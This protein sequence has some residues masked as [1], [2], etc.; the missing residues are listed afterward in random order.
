[1][2]L[3]MGNGISPMG[4]PNTIPAPLNAQLSAVTGSR[5]RGITELSGSQIFNLGSNGRANKRSR[6]EPHAGAPIPNMNGPLDGQRTNLLTTPYIHTPLHAPQRA[7]NQNAPYTRIVKRGSLPRNNGTVVPVVDTIA[8]HQWGIMHRVTGDQS[9]SY[10]TETRSVL[11]FDHDDGTSSSVDMTPQT[12]LAPAIWNYYN[13]VVQRAIFEKNPDMFLSLTAQDIMK[14]WV[15]DGVCI[16]EEMLSGA[17]SARSSGFS[18][19]GKWMGADGYKVCT[20]NL[21]NECHCF[22]VFG[23]SVI[24]GGALYAVVRK[25]RIPEHGAQFNFDFNVATKPASTVPFSRANLPSGASSKIQAM[26]TAAP[27][28]RFFPWQMF[29][30]CVPD[31]G[32]LPDA[33]RVFQ[34]EYGVTRYDSEVIYLGKVLIAPQ[35]MKPRPLPTSFL[36]VLG[37]IQDASLGSTEPLIKILVKPR[38][39]HPL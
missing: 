13:L 20:I 22:N 25:V 15:F 16:S 14:D 38:G 32:P 23:D 27:T 21:R 7:V 6:L 34:D 2:S 11:Q 10:T 8:K 29:L 17:E 33:H 1:M 24:E 5:K 9:A 4:I 26:A 30:I 19:G 28:E 18:R 37:P 12:I 36:N 3:N 35:G 39:H 31:D